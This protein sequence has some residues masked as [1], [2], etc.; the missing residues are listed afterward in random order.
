MSSARSRDRQYNPAA[1]KHGGCGQSILSYGEAATVSEKTGKSLPP[2]RR[3]SRWL[4][5]DGEV[6]L[7]EGSEEH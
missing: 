2:P 4:Q 1:R 7:E 6:W 3:R 5:A